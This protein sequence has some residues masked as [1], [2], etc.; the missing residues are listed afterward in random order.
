MRK[1]G[2]EDKSAA[3]GA[4]GLVV[5][6]AFGQGDCQVKVNY[7]VIGHDRDGFPEV[8]DSIFVFFLPAKCKPEAVEIMDVVGVLREREAI[9]GFRQIGPPHLH[10]KF[11]GRRALGRGV[12]LG[13]KRIVKRDTGR[14]FVAVLHELFGHFKLV[15]S[16]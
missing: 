4:D 16:H 13:F 5:I 8:D 2:L 11:R 7:S 1:M 9:F 3:E 14:V 12:G 6:L 15:I 10:E